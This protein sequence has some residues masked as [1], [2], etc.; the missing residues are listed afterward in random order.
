MEPAL[1]LGECGVLGVLPILL[2]L[3]FAD[4]EDRS[5]EWRLA[6]RLDRFILEVRARA[7][8]AIRRVRGAVRRSPPGI[9]AASCVY[10]AWNAFG[11]CAALDGGRGAH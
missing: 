5:W 6:E 8:M 9:C 2:G 11:C 1:R 10:D 4:D 7:S 3:G